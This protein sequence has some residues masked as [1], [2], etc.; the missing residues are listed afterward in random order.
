MTWSHTV[1][2]SIVSQKLRLTYMG[3]E[4]SWEVFSPTGFSSVITRAFSYPS[5]ETL[6][7]NNKNSGRGKAD[8]Q[9]KFRR[10]LCFLQ[11]HPPSENKRGSEREQVPL[12]P[13]LERP[14]TGEVRNPAGENGMSDG[15]ATS[16]QYRWIKAWNRSCLPVFRIGKTESYLEA[17]LL[18]SVGQWHWD[19]CPLTLPHPRPSRQSDNITAGPTGEE[20]SPRDMRQ[21]RHLAPVRSTGRKLSWNQINM[22]SKRGDHASDKGNTR[23]IKLMETLTNPTFPCALGDSVLYRGRSA[24]PL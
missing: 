8:I 13:S 22:V 6:E 23:T 17:V 7:E 19:T 15:S 4:A 18:C 16:V 9:K 3:D 12:F 20:K 11:L 24:W 1:N 14:G 21:E 5:A 2:L 10:G